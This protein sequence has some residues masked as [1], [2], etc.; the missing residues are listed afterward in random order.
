M[1]SDNLQL[2]NAVLY[3]LE[4]DCKWMALLKKVQRE[5]EQKYLLTDRAY[6]GESVPAAALEQRFEP[7]VP[8][9][10]KRKNPFIIIALRLLQ[11]VP[12]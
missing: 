3:V 12:S 1:K 10:K 9:K 7:V 11:E 8:L 5:K 6:E 4:N 2:I